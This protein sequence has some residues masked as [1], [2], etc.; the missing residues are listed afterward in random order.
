MVQQA[1]LFEYLFTFASHMDPCHLK[2]AELAET[3]SEV[4][5]GKSRG[6]G[7]QRQ[8]RQQ[9]QRSIR[10]ARRISFSSSNSNISGYNVQTSQYDRRSQRRCVGI[11]T[12][13]HAGSSKIAETTRERTPASMDKATALS[14]TTAMGRDSRTSC[15][16]WANRIRTL[17]GRSA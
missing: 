7:R 13:T 9:I 17:L 8:G 16:S 2:H 3:P 12:S 10:G 6:P 1:K 14:K 15:S 4:T 11:H 5:K